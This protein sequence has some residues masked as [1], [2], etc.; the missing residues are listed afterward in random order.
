MLLKAAVELG[1]RRWA[2]CGTLTAVLLDVL[3]R[4]E[5]E[6][7]SAKKGSIPEQTAECVL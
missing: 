3:H 7:L 2:C 1:I 5:K 4:G 6:P